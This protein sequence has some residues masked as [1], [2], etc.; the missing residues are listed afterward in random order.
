MIK[1]IHNENHIG[2]K[3]LTLTLT[4]KYYFKNMHKNIKLI[5]RACD[6]CV[7][8]K[9][10]FGNFIQPLSQLG[11]ASKPFQIISLDTIGGFS[12]NKSPKKYMHLVVDHFTKYAFVV[13]LKT[14]TAKDFINLVKKVQKKGRIKLL[15][16]DQYAGINSKEFKNFLKAENITNIFT[17]VD[18]PFSNGQNERTN[19]TLVNLIRCKIFENKDR[20]WSVIAEQGVENYNTIHSTTK[21]T[22][23]YLLNG[24]DKSFFPSELNENN[25]ENLERNRKIAFLNAE[26]IHNQN[27]VYYDK[28]K[29]EITYEVGD[30]VYIQNGNRLNRKKLDP[31]RVGPFKI[32]HK[33]SDLLYIIDSGFKTPESNVYHASKMIPYFQTLDS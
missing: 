13:T 6:T 30:L 33:I 23:N 31:V 22:P 12:G 28:H 17:A 8:N 7:R 16:T 1:K 5:C 10:R 9:S 20:P 21:F 25:L 3:Q 32:K 27:K 11:L 2:I 24:I 29:R 18:C 4:P 15:L 14:Q 19:Q 26:K